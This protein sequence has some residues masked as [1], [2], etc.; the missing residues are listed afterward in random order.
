MSL[1]QQNA[2]PERI[3]I[4]GAGVVGCA[5]AWALAREGRKVLLI[6]RAEPATAGASFG[7][8]GHIACEQREPLPSIPLLRT[9]WRELSVFGGAVDIPPHR[10]FVLA[11]WIALFI[12][13]AFRQARN[14]PA[15]AALVA[16][17]AQALESALRE[18]ARSELL[19]RHGH[20]TIW[21]G[22][23]AADRAARM[24]RAAAALSVRTTEA[25]QPLLE[26]VRK[27]DGGAPALGL[28]FPDSAHVTDPR[29]VAAAFAGAAV[30]AGAVFQ[31]NDVRELVPLGPR[32]GVRTD[33]AVAPAAAAVVC[34]GVESASLLRRFGLRA[35]L[36]SERGYHL[37][38]PGT[39]PLTDAPV[40]YADHNIIITPMRGRLRATTYLEFE[41]HGAPPDTR[42]LAR[43]HAR[44]ESLG[45]T[46]AT[47]HAGWVGSRPTLPD[48][49]P[50][51][52]RA[53]GEAPL[54]Y[55]FGH[56]HLGLTMAVP[57][58]QVMTDLVMGRAPSVDIRP[59]NLTRFGQPRRG[60]NL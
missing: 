2:D 55:A 54:F 18:I 16:P 34:A 21:R 32:I 42:K 29:E 38:L 39:P 30:Q 49:L 40:V 22:P 25:P 4:I 7:N 14:T 11:P 20:Y 41:R 27:R 48:Y 1:G 44:L 53:P 3:A 36:T 6:D 47:A 31:Q 45:Y 13:A 9:F 57:S 59:F 37:E 56:Q 58:A 46:S 26:A 10:W 24:A 60:A 28:H 12:Q 51:L 33:G 8:A 52:G 17:A 23:K 43:L 35:P 50:G 19:V 15:L 5:L